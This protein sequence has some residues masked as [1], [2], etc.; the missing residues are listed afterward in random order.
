MPVNAQKKTP[1]KTTVKTPLGTKAPNSSKANTQNSDKAEFPLLYYCSFCRKPSTSVKSLIA[2]PNNIFI[3]DNCLEI[4]VR[5][6]LEDD[7]E[8]WQN[9]LT[10]MLANNQ[11]KEQK[12]TKKKGKKTNADDTH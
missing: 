4:G 1:A 9:R 2:G 8:G 11:K 6:L 7:V 5:I 12:S 10:S 3:C